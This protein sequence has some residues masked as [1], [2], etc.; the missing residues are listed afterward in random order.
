MVIIGQRVHGDRPI[1]VKAHTRKLAMPIHTL[2]KY[3][4]QDKS[5][6]KFLNME[7]EQVNVDLWFKS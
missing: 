5:T 3:M 6:R 1:I 7:S 2:R 4:M